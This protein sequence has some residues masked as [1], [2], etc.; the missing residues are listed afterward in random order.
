MLIPGFFTAGEADSMEGRMATIMAGMPPA[1]H[2]FSTESHNQNRDDYFLSSGDKV[3]VH[4]VLHQMLYHI[5]YAVPYCAVLFIGQGVLGGEE[6]WGQG[7]TAQQ[8]RARPA[9]PR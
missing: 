1:E 3:T 6:G 8:V 9:R 4:S 7:A 2:F 5:Q